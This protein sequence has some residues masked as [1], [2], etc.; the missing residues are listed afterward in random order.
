MTAPITAAFALAILLLITLLAAN[1]SRLRMRHRGSK[2]PAAAEEIR[3]ASRA[4]GNNLEHGIVVIL[5]MLFCEL[6]GAGA[7]LLG[8]AGAAYLLARL[9]YSYGYLT[10]PGRRAMFFGAAATYA[11]EAILIVRL[12]VLL[13]RV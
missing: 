10:A 1:T 8:G 5:L 12:G 2:D 4:H 11:I 13:L 7:P 3:R 9:G 6:S